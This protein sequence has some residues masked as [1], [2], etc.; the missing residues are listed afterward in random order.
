MHAYTGKHQKRFWTLIRRCA[1]H[2]LSVIRITVLDLEPNPCFLIFL[3]ISKTTH[4]IVNCN[5]SNRTSGQELPFVFFELRAPTCLWG[6]YDPKPKNFTF[7]HIYLLHIHSLSRRSTCML[8]LIYLTA[9][10][11][12]DL[13]VL[14]AVWFTSSVLRNLVFETM[15]WSTFVDLQ[16]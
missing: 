4:Q 5:I 16:G 14:C 2:I 15:S 11:F 13:T 1:V 6:H 7:F 3:N 10:K 8:T 9:W 12:D